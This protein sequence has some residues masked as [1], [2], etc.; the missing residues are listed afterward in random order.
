MQFIGQEISFWETFFL[1]LT[2]TREYNCDDY[3]LPLEKDSGSF[4]SEKAL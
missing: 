1:A 2:T 3:G 4:A